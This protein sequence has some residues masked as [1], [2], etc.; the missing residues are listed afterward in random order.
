MDLKGTDLERTMN[1]LGLVNDPAVADTAKVILQHLGDYPYEVE[2]FSKNRRG[3]SVNQ[4]VYLSNLAGLS[5]EDTGSLYMVFDLAG[6]LSSQQ[7][8]FLI[9]KLKDQKSRCTETL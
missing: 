7:A 2:D 8:H 6:G 3:A 9:Q 5:V 1:L 4:I